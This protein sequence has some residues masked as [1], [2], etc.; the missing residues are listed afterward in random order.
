MRDDKG[1]EYSP[2]AG[3]NVYFPEGKQPMPPQKA[4]MS[5]LICALSNG[6]NALLE[7]PTGTGKT[8]AL[9]CGSISWQR[10][11]KGLVVGATGTDPAASTPSS[12]AEGRPH[13]NLHYEESQS[14]SKRQKPEEPARH[15]PRIYYCSRTHSQLDQV[16]DCSRVRFSM[17]L[18]A[19][20]SVLSLEW[21][22]MS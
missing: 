18:P 19:S 7:S 15:A 12:S 22:A 5:K 8:L 9:L 13:T 10:S 20:R 1:T 6:Q 2:I 4:V 11:D 3:V 21:D 14:P 16:K 17:T